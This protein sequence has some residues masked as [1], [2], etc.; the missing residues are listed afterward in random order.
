MAKPPNIDTR[1]IENGI[2]HVYVRNWKL[3][4]KFITNQLQNYPGYVFR[5]Q[6]KSEWLLKTTLDRLREN[7]NKTIKEKNHLNAFK[8]AARGRRGSSANSLSEND[9]W[10]LG[11]HYGLATPL[12]DFTRSPFVALY[13]SFL[14]ESDST[15]RSVFAVHANGIMEKSKEI[16]SAK[17]ESE[18]IDLFTPMTEENDR[19]INQAG[20]FARLPPESHLEDWVETHFS[21]ITD[22]AILI[23]I[24]IPNRMI[25]ECL[26]NLNR[27][28]INHLTL[29]PD[30]LGASIH[31]NTLSVMAK[32]DSLG[33]I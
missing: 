31:V 32:Y 5:G 11:Q 7:S 13:F 22:K 1:A 24:H 12:L 21:G 33:A 10:S 20:V 26:I 23:K 4:N 19:L 6:S 29:F 16:K 8:M 17:D 14:E 2:M 25:E 28:N 9:W 18:I 30:L 27:S 15:Y 3:F